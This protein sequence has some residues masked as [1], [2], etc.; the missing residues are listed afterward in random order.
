MDNNK[1]LV[2]VAIIVAG[3][4][5]AWGVMSKGTPSTSTDT[6]NDNFTACLVDKATTNKVEAYYQSGL[7]AGVQGTPHSILIAKNGNKRV[8]GG[9]LPYDDYTDGAG[10]QQQGVKSMVEEM[11]NSETIANQEVI[12]VDP[13]TADDHILGSPDADVIMVEYSDLECPFCK[14]FHLTTKQIMAEYGENGQ[15]ALVFRHFP[16]D[17]LHS[18]ARTEAAATECAAEI[19]GN[20]VFW[21]YLD[22]VFEITPSNNGLELSKLHDIAVEMDLIK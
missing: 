4:L 9:A 17:Q 14:N 7:K 6:P 2:P 5:I 13:V 1:F 12:N 22:K 19:G 15:V 21:A 3:G 11:L 16:L 10:V 18:K 8:I 20:D